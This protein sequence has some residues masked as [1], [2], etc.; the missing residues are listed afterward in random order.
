VSENLNILSTIKQ[1]GHDIPQVSMDLLWTDR[2]GTLKA[3]FALN[4]MNY[5]VEPGLYAVGQPTDESP[6]LV[7]ANYKMSFDYLRSRLK[8]LP[9]MGIPGV[10]ILVL[11]TKGINV[12]CA[13]GK[14]TFGAEELVHRIKATELR[15]IVKHRTLIVPQLGAPGVSGHQVRQLS[16]FRV[17]FGPVRADDIPEFLK[18]NMKATESMRKV[19]FPL[20]D[21]TVLIPV[22]LM[23]WGKYII[24]AMLCFFLLSGLNQEGYASSLAM[25]HGIPNAG[26]LILIFLA[27]GILGPVLLPWLPG[28]SF[29]LKGLWIALI[30]LA[31]LAWYH[32]PL[33]H[34]SISWLTIAA[35]IFIIPTVITF[36][37]MNFTGAST[38]TSLSGVRREMCVAVPL[39]LTGAI[40]GVILFIIGQFF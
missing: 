1:N 31:G 6:V 27:G 26:L 2:L 17:V 34:T 22:E 23:L 7:S 32:W 3:R 30:S 12:W 29:S 19:T 15:D 5:M 8:N 36:V 40:F 10:W 25:S 9:Q 18:A 33:N 39:Q 24:F 35:W 37:V 21:R 28:R 16:G 13:A 20:W 14:G 4:R 38:Y 11:D